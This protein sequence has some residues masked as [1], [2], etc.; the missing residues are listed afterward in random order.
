MSNP[1]ILESQRDHTLLFHIEVKGED[2]FGNLYLL[3]HRISPSF[4]NEA[5]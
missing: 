3:P 1:L 4:P 5:L 2:L